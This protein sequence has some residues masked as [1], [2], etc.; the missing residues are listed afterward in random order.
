[1]ATIKER[2]QS[3]AAHVE[4]CRGELVKAQNEFDVLYKQATGGR[5]KKAKTDM[6]KTL[7]VNLLDEVDT[8]PTQIRALLDG[9]PVRQWSYDDIRLKLPEIPRP[10]IRVHLY[11]LQKDGAVKKVGRGKWQAAQEPNVLPM[12]GRA[13]L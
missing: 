5:A 6:P 8:S 9:E 3:A 12:E 7:E 4:H 10:S 13:I 2:L 1:M 11:K